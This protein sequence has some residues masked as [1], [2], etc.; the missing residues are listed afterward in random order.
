MKL[1]NG[2]IQAAVEAMGELC[3]PLNRLPTLA[4]LKAARTLRA[5]AHAWEPCDAVRRRLIEEHGEAIPGGHQVRPG[6]PG[7]EAYVAAIAEMGAQEQEVAVE[8]VALADVE[9]GYSRDPETRRKGPLDVA[10]VRLGL[11]I[12]LGLVASENG[13]QDDAAGGAAS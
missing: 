10:P 5:M 8:P 11:L 3:G 2:Q 7:W 4:A 12:E 13:K 6:M 1:T 9:A